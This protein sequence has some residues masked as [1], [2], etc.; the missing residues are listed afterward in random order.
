MP[1]ASPEPPAKVFKGKVLSSI[2][3]ALLMRGGMTIT[4]IARE[5][6]RRASSAS[7]GRDV[8]ANIR[9]RIHW[10]QQRGL[11][12]HRDEAGRVQ[13][14]QDIPDVGGVSGRFAQ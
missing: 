9:A 11:K 2:I 13:I 8:R 10:L 5:V 7:A 6:Q 3:D 14:R 12:L 1:V 4:G